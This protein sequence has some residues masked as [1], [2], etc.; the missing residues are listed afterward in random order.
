MLALGWV[1]NRHLSG[2]PGLRGE[3]GSG[4]PTAN[5]C[6][7]LRA[8]FCMWAP[9]KGP[10]KTNRWTRDLYNEKL[11]HASPVFHSGFA[12]W[13]YCR[14]G[15]TLWLPAGGQGR[16]GAGW[17]LHIPLMGPPLPC[18]SDVMAM[19]QHQFS[20]VSLD[21]EMLWWTTGSPGCAMTSPKALPL[22]C[23]ER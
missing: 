8:G 1:P 4:L 18:L 19:V 5:K 20:R 14:Y 13:S 17:H 10:L 3:R 2:S 23:L 7:W 22:N 9:G 12:S 6:I 21:Q 16:A 15:G 11:R